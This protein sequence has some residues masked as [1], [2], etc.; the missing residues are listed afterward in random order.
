MLLGHPCE[1]KDVFWCGL[2]VLSVSFGVFFFNTFKQP[3]MKGSILFEDG[4]CFIV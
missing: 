3:S 2:V 4:P 1:H